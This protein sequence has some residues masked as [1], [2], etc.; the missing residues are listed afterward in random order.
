MDRANIVISVLSLIGTYVSL[1]IQL[2]KSG[3]IRK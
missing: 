1:S 3:M 2:L